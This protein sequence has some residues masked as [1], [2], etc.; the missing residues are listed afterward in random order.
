MLQEMM[1]HALWG[2]SSTLSALVSLM[3]L[4]RA[5][6]SRMVGLSWGAQEQAARVRLAWGERGGA[7]K[8]KAA[9]SAAMEGARSIEC[10]PQLG[11]CVP[12]VG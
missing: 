2:G 12:C 8:G 4:S 5:M 11:V 9:G 1:Q 3:A 7:S 6:T 10:S